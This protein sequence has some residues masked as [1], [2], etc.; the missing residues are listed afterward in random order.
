GNAD[1]FVTKIK[2]DGTQLIYSTYLGGS[3]FDEAYGIAVD[4]G[5]SA[6]VVGATASG[7]FNTLNPF[8]ANNA[9][10]GSDGFLARI[11]SNGTALAYSTYFGGSGVDVAYGVAVDANLNA[12]ITGHTFSNDLPT[13]NP[14]QSLNR[15]NADAFVARFNLSGSALV[16]STY[17][18]GALGDFGRGIVVDS[19]SQPI[20]TGRTG[21][22]DF[23]TLNP[24][25]ASNRGNVDAFV[26][27]LNINGTQLVY[28]TY[29]G[30]ISEDLAYGI[31]IDSTGAVYVT[32]DTL[33]TDFNTRTP[34]QSANRGGFDAFVTKVN[35]AGSDLAYSTYLGGSGEDLASSI[36]LDTAGNAYITG[37]T[38]SNDYATISPIQATSRGGLEVFVTKIFADASSIAFNTYFG[39][40]GSDNANSIAVDSGG[41]CYIT[42][43]TT[44][45]N[46]PTRTP[47]QATNRGGLE[48]FVA[49]FN[50]TGTNI[51]YSTYLGGQFGDV[52]RSIAVDAAGNAWIAGGT[53]SNDFPV[54]SA[55]Q[56]TSRGLGDA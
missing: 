44:S 14:L 8:Q 12:Y 15:G 26:S 39:G 31:A 7:D 29:L 24:L 41:N 19:G 35:P 53:F 17:L 13:Q 28:S 27:K 1:A 33:S 52:G 56:P 16:Y 9:G 21:S 23:N 49:K 11:N 3:D 30:G 38:S 54:A 50:S 37:Y 45:T 25:Q 4:S 47:I 32:G 5:G 55:F 22:T 6:Y 10:A 34:L 40:N 42:G 51:I 36:A 46:F 43:S 20:I 48:V 18:G 2:G